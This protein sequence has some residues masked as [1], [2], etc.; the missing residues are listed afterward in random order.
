MVE[1]GSFL[2]VIIAKRTIRVA[3]V[4]YSRLEC[5]DRPIDALFDRWPINSSRRAGA[6]MPFHL[7]VTTRAPFLSRTNAARAVSR[8]TL[9]AV[10]AR[11]R[12]ATQ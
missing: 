9:G 4:G 2:P 3:Q 11:F 1:G 10:I 8:P 5:R 7:L 12:R 6:K